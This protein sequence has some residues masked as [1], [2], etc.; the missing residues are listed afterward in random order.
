MEQRIVR[1]RRDLYA[2][3]RNWR[4]QPFVLFVLLFAF[5]FSV[6]MSLAITNFGLLTRERVMLL[7][8]AMMLFCTRG[9]AAPAAQRVAP[10][11]GWQPA[12]A[13]RPVALYR[14]AGSHRAQGGA[15]PAGT[16][17]QE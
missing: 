10:E 1:R 15:G 8:F 3:V 2:A 16:G 6:V 4:N 11:R 13:P 14:R 7:P 12:A 9:E 5:Q 17:R